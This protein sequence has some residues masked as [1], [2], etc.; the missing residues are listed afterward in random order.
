MKAK[1][2]AIA[3][4]TRFYE[5]AAERY[6]IMRNDVPLEMYISANIQACL[7]NLRNGVWSIE[8]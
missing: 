5:R 6:P 7:R 2:A 8:D 3:R 1:D 4:L